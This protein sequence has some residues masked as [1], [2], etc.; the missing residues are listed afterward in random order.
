MSVTLTLIPSEERTLVAF[1][2]STHMGSLTLMFLWIL[3]S[4]RPS[5]IISSAVMDMASAEM[6]PSTTSAISFTRVLTS[7]PS[8][9]MRLGLVVTPS[10]IPQLLISLIMSRFAVSMKIFMFM[11]SLKW[12]SLL[13][14]R[15][16][17]R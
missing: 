7:T 6:G 11:P 8:L 3:A 1:R 2:V 16:H 12:I 13:P 4:S 14:R 15:Y 9:A 10:R 17:P 5:L